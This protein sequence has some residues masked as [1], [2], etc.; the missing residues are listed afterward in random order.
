MTRH[1][2]EQ[3]AVDDARSKARRYRRIY[4]VASTPTGQWAVVTYNA[5]Y[6]S[7]PTRIGPAR[8]VINPDGDMSAR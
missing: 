3:A 5:F 2:T 7:A 4:F 1:Q 6:S 8:W